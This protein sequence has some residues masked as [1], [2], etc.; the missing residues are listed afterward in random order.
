[1]H[2]QTFVTVSTG[3]PVVTWRVSRLSPLG[4]PLETLTVYQTAQHPDLERNLIDYF[5]EKVSRREG[6]SEIRGHRA[7]ARDSA[8]EVV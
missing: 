1:M 5:S 4:V 3:Q 7:G 8:F 6:I 2:V